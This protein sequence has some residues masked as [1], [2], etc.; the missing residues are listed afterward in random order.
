MRSPQEKNTRLENM[1]WRIWNLARKKKEVR[2]FA[3]GSFL[4]SLRAA[5]YVP[6]AVRGDVSVI[7]SVCWAAERGAVG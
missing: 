4:L 3:L 5:C 2:L 6:D 7:Q 1:T